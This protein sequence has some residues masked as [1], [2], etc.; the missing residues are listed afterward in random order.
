[1]TFALLY[2]SYESVNSQPMKKNIIPR[3]ACAAKAYSSL[4]VFP[5]VIPSF[6]QLPG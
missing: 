5:S 2:L 6:C 1:M 3:C 4:L